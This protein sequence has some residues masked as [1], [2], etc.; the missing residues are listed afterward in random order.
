[1]SVYLR[2]VMTMATTDCSSLIAACISAI[3]ETKSIAPGNEIAC[4]YI[5]VNGKRQMK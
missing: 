1:M 5:P 4:V 3:N 2:L